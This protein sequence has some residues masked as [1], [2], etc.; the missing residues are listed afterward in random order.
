MSAKPFLDTNILVYAY[1]RHE[2]AKQQVAQGILRGALADDSAVLS[3][4]VLTEFYVTVTRKIPEPLAS[5]EAREIIE[6]VGILPT[7]AVDRALVRRAIEV[8]DRY[9]VSLWDS[10]IISAAERGHCTEILSEDLGD[11]QEYAGIV[12]RNPFA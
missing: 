10:L 12:V 3:A 2:P 1:D 4:Q 7:I 8:H 9:Q 5:A 6:L 11:G